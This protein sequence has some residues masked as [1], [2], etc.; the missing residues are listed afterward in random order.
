MRDISETEFFGKTWTF[1]AGAFFFTPFALFC[2]TLGPLF[3]F[4]VMKPADGRPGTVPGIAISS[5]TVPCLLFSALAWFN[6]AARRRPLLKLFSDGFKVNVIGASSWD[7]VAWI[8]SLIRLA[9]KLLSGAAF[10]SK[11]GWIPWETIRSVEV[12]GLPMMRILLIHATV[13]YPSKVG[14]DMSATT[15]DYVAFREDELRVPLDEISVAI[16]EFLDFPK[17][18]DALPNLRDS[19]F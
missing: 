4:G 9:L 14:K 18:R 5:M 13:V 17:N 16:Q 10:R 8:P 6:V 11:I 7:A 2:L 15:A 19:Q 1:Y 12:S 3:L